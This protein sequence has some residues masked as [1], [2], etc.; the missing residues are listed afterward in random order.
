M[1]DKPVTPPLSPELQRVL[2]LLSAIH[3]LTTDMNEKATELK[4][5]TTQTSKQLKTQN[6]KLVVNLI[7]IS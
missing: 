6:N 7:D 4:H 1:I 2:D 5:L 3:T